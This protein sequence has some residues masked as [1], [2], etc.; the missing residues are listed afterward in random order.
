[1]VYIGKYKK[2]ADQF[3]KD[4]VEEYQI[5]KFIREEMERDVFE[6]EN[7]TTNLEAYRIWKSWP[8]E[9]RELLLNNALCSNCGGV[10]S[11]APGYSVRKGKWGL[12]LQGNCVKCGG[13]IRR[14]CD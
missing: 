1:M 10:T 8:E 5:E 7:D 3:R 13:R 11:F 2:M 6:I 12:I 9:R 4:G 14:V